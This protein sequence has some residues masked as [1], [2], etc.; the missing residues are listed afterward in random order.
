[1]KMSN[2]FIHYIDGIFKLQV[3]RVSARVIQFI[4]VKEHLYFVNLLPLL[5]KWISIT[6]CN[7]HQIEAIET[8]PMNWPCVFVCGVCL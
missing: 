3:I 6:S 2:D 7:C 4:C 5:T 1:M 8:V